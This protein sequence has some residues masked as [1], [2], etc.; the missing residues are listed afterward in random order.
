[1]DE[2]VNHPASLP[3]GNYPE[4]TRRGFQIAGAALFFDLCG[5]NYSVG[6]YFFHVTAGGS[7]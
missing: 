3:V 2:T 7:S 5:E 4:L 1:V 6:F